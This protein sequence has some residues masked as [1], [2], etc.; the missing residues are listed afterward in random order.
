[1]VGLDERL[2]RVMMDDRFEL[3]GVDPW[4]FFT[5][6]RGGSWVNWD[7]RLFLWVGDHLLLITMGGIVN[8]AVLVWAVR[9]CMGGSKGMKKGALRRDGGRGW[10]ARLVGSEDEIL[11][12]RRRDD[13]DDD[14]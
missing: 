2:V 13:N 8:V 4:I 11:P 14:V 6:E 9:R 12:R 5:Q 10:Y 3:E 1:M 7:N